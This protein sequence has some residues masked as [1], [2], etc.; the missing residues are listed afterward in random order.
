VKSRG[1]TRFAA[2]RSL[3]F[4]IARKLDFTRIN[5]RAG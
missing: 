5:P 1:D 3:L 2:M 4:L